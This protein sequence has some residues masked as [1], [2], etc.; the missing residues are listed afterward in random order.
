MF[1]TLW[2]KFEDEN[3]CIEPGVIFTDEEGF[4]YVLVEK[5]D[6]L[7]FEVYN[8]SDQEVSTL[9]PCL[10]FWDM[11]EVKRSRKKVVYDPSVF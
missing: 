2:K 1:K 4:R 11:P 9:K 8:C 10:H 7:C 5:R 6:G 3:G